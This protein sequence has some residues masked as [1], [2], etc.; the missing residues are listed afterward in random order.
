MGFYPVAVYYN[1]TQHTNMW[2]VVYYRVSE[3]ECTHFKHLNRARKSPDFTTWN[4]YSESLSSCFSIS[5]HFYLS[6]LC[7]SRNVRSVFKYHETD[8]CAYSCKLN[9]TSIV[10]KTSTVPHTNSSQ[11]SLAV[12]WYRFP[13]ADVP[14]PLGSRTVPGLSYQLLTPHNCNSHLK[15]KVKVTLR[16][17]VCRQSVLAAIPLRLTTRDFFNWALAVSLYVTSSLMRRWVS[18]LWICSAFRQVYE[19]HM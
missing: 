9:R 7:F 1:K 16:L 14:L 15:V 3:K 17:A 13:T 12:A 8:A 10:H 19:S 5:L 6:S 2:S 4:I 11:S 18:L